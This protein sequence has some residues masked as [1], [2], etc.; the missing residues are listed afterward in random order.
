MSNG[1]TALVAP[2]DGAIESIR[3]AGAIAVADRKEIG[4][5]SSQIAGLEWGRSF[6]ENGRYAIAAFARVTRANVTVH[7]DILGGKP[8]LNAQYWAD[9]IVQHERFH[10]YV[11]RDLSPSVEQALRDRAVRHTDL[12][13]KDDKKRLGKA[14][15]LIDQ[16]DDMVVDR[17]RWSPRE[18]ATV[19]IETTIMRFINAAPLEKIASGEITDLEPYLVAVT[20]CNWAGGMGKTMAD[21]KKYDPIGDANPGTT[22]RSRSLRRCATKAFSAWAEEYNNQIEKAENT[23]MAEFEIIQG[24]EVAAATEA[25]HPGDPV[26]VLGSGE[27]TAVSA[28]DAE[29]LPVEEIPV[30]EEEEAEPEFDPTEPRKRFFATFRD[31]GMD[32]KERKTWAKSNGL[33]QSSKDW[34]QE[35]Y[36]RAQGILMDPVRKAV[37]K[38]VGGKKKALNDLCLEVLQKEEPEFLRDWNALLAVLDARAAGEDVEPDEDD[39]L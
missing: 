15:D 2:T 6:S 19:V 11:Q 18:T 14:L 9:F 5:I 34:G 39:D 7:I 13:S 36:D 20:E 26:A 38:A 29:E 35:E 24:E 30:V 28:E 17:A 16:A 4:L 1:S 10:H 31:A 21:K 25:L 3:R 23:I 27:P 33:P 8:Y 22:A 12:A 37:S 32:E